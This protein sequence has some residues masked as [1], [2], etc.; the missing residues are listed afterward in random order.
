MR[1]RICTLLCGLSLVLLLSACSTQKKSSNTTDTTGTAESSQI[2]KNDTIV[3]GIELKVSGVTKKTVV[4]AKK[5][6]CTVYFAK[7]EGKNVSSS[8]KG[9]GAIDFLL[10]MKDGKEKEVST[11]LNSFGNEIQP[12]ATIKGELYFPLKEN[13]I[14][15]SIEYKPANDVLYSWNVNK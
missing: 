7:V 9:L 11:D 1:K 5:K 8:A 4:D 13:E 15:K 3:D 10:K 14:P 6:K 2:T 12:E